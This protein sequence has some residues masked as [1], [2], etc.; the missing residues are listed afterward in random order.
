[1]KWIK[2]FFRRLMYPAT[3]N[4]PLFGYI[5]HRV[6]GSVYEVVGYARLEASEWPPAQGDRLVIYRAADGTLYAREEDETFQ[7][8][9][10]SWVR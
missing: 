5:R 1:M 3:V 9:R 8:G 10:F 7:H 4:M 6:R 2:A